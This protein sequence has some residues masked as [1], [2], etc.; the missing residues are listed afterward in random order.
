[1]FKCERNNVFTKE[2]NK[3][4]EIKHETDEIKKWEDKFKRK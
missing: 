4:N 1:M 3:T 2:I